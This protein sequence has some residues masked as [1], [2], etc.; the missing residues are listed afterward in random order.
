MGVFENIKKSAKDMTGLGL[1]PMEHYNRAYEKGV[2]LQPPDYNSAI[3]EFNAASAGFEKEG[4]PKSAKTARANAALYKLV[5]T[6]DLSSIVEAIKS[7]ESL[8]EIHR[9]GSRDE[10]IPTDALITEL[11]ALQYEYQAEAAAETNVKKE[12]YSKASDTIMKL[13]VNPLNITDRINLAGPVDKAMMRSYYYG[14]LS[15]YYAAL[16]EVAESPENAHDSLDKSIQKF[17]QAQTTPW[18]EKV[19]VFRENVS[20]KRFCWMCDRE[21]QGKDI[22][23][24]YYPAITKPYH[25]HVLAKLKQDVLMV[26]IPNNVTLC[27]VCGS[28]IE[29]QADRYAKMRVEELRKEL[30]PILQRH[31]DTLAAHEQRIRNLENAAHSHT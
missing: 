14:A 8:P 25:S 4:K 29:L 15:D 31:E 17:I 10:K 22:Y 20:S 21:M 27:T 26:E 6:K 23:Y 28:A 13:G 2:F 5:N 3:K 12:E 7:L 24:Q 9:I 16:T 11:T 19:K 30:I 1:S 18:V